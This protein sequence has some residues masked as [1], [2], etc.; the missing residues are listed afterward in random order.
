MIAKYMLEIGAGSKVTVFDI[1]AFVQKY[2][3]DQHFCA[4]IVRLEDD[5]FFFEPC[6]YQGQLLDS[7]VSHEVECF[8][9][10]EK[11]FCVFEHFL[12]SVRAKFPGISFDQIMVESTLNWLSVWQQ[13][14]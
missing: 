2:L 3:N 13:I 9:A 7:E 14:D 12:Q 4:L 8:G 1:V 5:H 11:P 6:P 10:P